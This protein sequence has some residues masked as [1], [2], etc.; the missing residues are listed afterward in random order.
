MST[1]HKSS[2]E[3]MG[4]LW[5][6]YL[7]PYIGLLGVAFIFMLIEGST[8]GGL[9]YMMQPMF[10]HVFVA[11]NGD[12]LFWVSMA[13]LIIFSVR[14]ITSVCQKVILAKIAQTSAAHLR[15]D[16]LARM[17]RQDPSFHQ[18]HPPGALIQRIQTDVGAINQVWRSVITGAGRDV[19]QLFATLY[20]AL[21]VDW[22]W[23]LI[24]LVGLP[25]LLIP[26][27][28]VQ[29]YVRKKASRARDLG[30]SLATRLDEI[31]HGI[32]PIKL[33]SLE[34]YQEE[35]FAHHTDEFVR[36]EVKAQFGTSSITGMIDIMAGLG[37]MG[38][39]LYGGQQIIGGEKTVGQFM[40]FFTAIGL[41]FDPMRRLANMSGVWQAAA[42]AMERIK[43][44]MDAPIELTEPEN[45]KPAPKGLPEIQLENVSLEYGSARV[46]RNLTLVAEAGKTTALVGASGAGKSTIFNLLTRLVDPVEGRATLGGVAVNEMALKDLRDLF[47]VVTQEALLF[48]E[49]LRENILLGRTDVSEEALQEVLDAAHVSDFLPK[50]SDGLDTLVGPRGSALSGGQRQR[51]VIARALLRNTPILLLDE[52]TSALDAQSEK[53]V[54]SALDKLSGGRTTLVIAHRLSTI[55][56]A[57]KIVVMERGEIAD[58]GTHEELLER[59]GIYA[60]LYRLQFQDGKTLVDPEGVAAQL[61]EAVATATAPETSWLRRLARRFSR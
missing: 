21:M 13:F 54:Q 42:A 14:G 31:F 1:P 24:M 15:R 35:R 16:M 55:R 6:G 44:L 37:V 3:L 30:A 58:Q 29:R 23:T 41:T 34:E 45:P 20:V 28:S 18:S 19:T 2:R 47:S 40:S 33:N 26:I 7:R 11:G 38:V 22:R 52:A 27:A 36:Q 9:A 48:D 32:V 4:W 8:V 61:P 5:K 46:L 39:V 51:V 50:L 59:G 25:M 56:S 49:T 57:D 53:V 12:A 17:I 43:G 10:D 60:D